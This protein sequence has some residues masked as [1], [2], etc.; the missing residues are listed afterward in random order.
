MIAILNERQLLVQVIMAELDLIL[1][2]DLSNR[3]T[4]I[5]GL[6]LMS[7]LLLRLSTLSEKAEAGIYL[8]KM[9]PVP[10][11]GSTIGQQ[12]RLTVTR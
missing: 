1:I 2:A 3:L 4:G 12:D 9:P 10:N 6:R 7:I 5:G 11:P 8:P